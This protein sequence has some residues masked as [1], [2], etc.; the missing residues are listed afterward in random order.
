MTAAV[1]FAAITLSVLVVSASPSD[2]SH[3][4]RGK[5]PL[6]HASLHAVA[7][8]YPPSIQTGHLMSNRQTATRSARVPHHVLGARRVPARFIQPLCQGQASRRT[9]V[10]EWRGSGLWGSSE[11]ST[12]HTHT[13]TNTQAQHVQHTL[14][15]NA[16]THSQAQHAQHIH[17]QHVQG[18]AE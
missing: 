18:R 1:A 7:P 5:F 10:Q 15:H 2:H 6:L 13:Q 17:T 11:H 3:C 16:H 8:I 4:T 14:T 9:R 12:Q